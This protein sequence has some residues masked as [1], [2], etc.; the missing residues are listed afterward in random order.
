MV[1]VIN[2]G[3]GVYLIGYRSWCMCN[4]IKVMV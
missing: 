1:C 3:G 2:R 4:K